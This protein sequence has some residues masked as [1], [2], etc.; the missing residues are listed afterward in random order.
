MPTHAFISYSRQDTSFVERLEAALN[1]RGV[2]TW[3]DSTFAFLEQS[4]AEFGQRGSGK[5]A[6]LPVHE[7]S[8]LLLCVPTASIAIGVTVRPQ[9]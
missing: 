9:G 3:R 8:D 2:I 4:I 5:G 6:I 7:R 1:A